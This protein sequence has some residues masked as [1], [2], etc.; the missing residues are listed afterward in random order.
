MHYKIF[1]PGFVPTKL[2]EESQTIREPFS[3]R[4][5]DPYFPRVATK[6]P[7]GKEYACSAQRTK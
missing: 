6:P 4:I 3:L 2:F 1:Y 7:S 5:V